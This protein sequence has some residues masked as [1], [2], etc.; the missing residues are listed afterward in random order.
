MRDHKALLISMYGLDAKPYHTEKTDITWENCSLRRWL[1]KDFMNKA[2]TAQEQAGIVLTSVDNSKSQGYSG[3]S[4]Y[5]GNTTQDNVFLL[6][7]AEANKYL[8]VTS[9]NPNNTI[10]RAAL[11]AYAIK[12]GA[13]TSGSNK[14]PEGTAAGWWW[15]RSPGGGQDYAADVCADGSLSNF[16]VNDGS[17]CVRPALWINLESDLFRS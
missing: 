3:Y 11:T 7:Y 1:S 15:L 16:S 6:S 2:F 17:G 14:T 12:N 10:S 13:Y 4:T 8:G 9:D 5:G